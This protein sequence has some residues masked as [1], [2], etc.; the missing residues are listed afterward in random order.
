MGQGER[1]GD[2]LG[3][4]PELPQNGHGV[5]DRVVGDV[6]LFPVGEGTEGDVL[7]LSL[8]EGFHV[9]SEEGSDEVVA[10]GPR[11]LQ[12]F[13]H[14]DAVYFCHRLFKQGLVDVIF[15]CKLDVR[16][17]FPSS[18]EDGGGGLL[19]R[20]GAHGGHGGNSCMECS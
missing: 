4:L 3:E 15:P 14:V 16:L 8:P 9:A 11:G 10:D 17:F 7:L 5:P 18:G 6:E 13:Q 2:V 19:L 1:L 12:A 20:P